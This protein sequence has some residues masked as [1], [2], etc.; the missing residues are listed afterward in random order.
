[1]S[2]DDISQMLFIFS[3][4][5]L[6]TS[7]EGKGPYSHYCPFY[8]PVSPLCPIQYGFVK[9]IGWN[10]FSP[11]HFHF[12]MYTKKSFLFT[13]VVIIRR[14]TMWPCFWPLPIPFEGPL[15]FHPDYCRYK[16]NH[17]LIRIFSLFFTIPF[18]CRW[19]LKK[20]FEMGGNKSK[21]I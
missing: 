9:G 3:L 6:L 19:T 4:S 1:M 5:L 8:S 10:R 14:T 11:Q 18:L 12:M 13:H 20:G 17:K 7:G 21:N 2:I 15:E 16:S